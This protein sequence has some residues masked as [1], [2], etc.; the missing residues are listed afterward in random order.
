MEDPQQLLAA[1]N[2]TSTI[3]IVFVVGTDPVELGLVASLARRGGNLTGAAM[4]MTELNAKYG[5][6]QVSR[7]R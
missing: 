2:A 7:N 3:P 1:K 4:L 6:H 5:R